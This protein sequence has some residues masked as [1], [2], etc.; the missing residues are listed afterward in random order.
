MR[1]KDA[2][3]SREAPVSPQKD[4]KTKLAPALLSSSQFD[5]AVPV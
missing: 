3:P 4:R 5:S 2:A 1:E